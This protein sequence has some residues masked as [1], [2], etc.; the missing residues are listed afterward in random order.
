VPILLTTAGGEKKMAGMIPT[1]SSGVSGPLGV[2]H[3][4]RFWSKVLMDAKGVLH[5]DYPACGAGFDQLV[6]DRLGLDKE[7]TLAYIAENSPTYPQFEAWVLEQSGGSLD[8]NVVA[9]LNAA[10]TGYNHDDETRGSILG[11]SDID[12]DGS[13]LDAI[14]LNNLD[15]WYEFHASLG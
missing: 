7:A 14:N 6:L 2:L 12:D 4:P 3:L 9:E 11:A 5:E 8:Q 13:I 1:I 10:I 15:D